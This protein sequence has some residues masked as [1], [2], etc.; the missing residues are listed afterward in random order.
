MWW[1]MALALAAPAPGPAWAQRPFCG[2]GEGVAGLRQA[3]EALSRPVEGLLA[4]REAGLAIAGVLDGAHAAFARCG[5]PRLA[6]TLAEPARMAESAASQ[7][8][9]SA[10]AETFRQTGLRIR[11]ARQQLERDGCR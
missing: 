2:Y 7:A 5:C 10:V 8:S 1:L 3:Q 11:L 9:V 4:G 6:E